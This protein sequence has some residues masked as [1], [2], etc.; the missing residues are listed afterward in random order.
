MNNKH[1]GIY[2]GNSGDSENGSRSNKDGGGD[3]GDAYGDGGG[4]DCRGDVGENE[5]YNNDDVRDGSEEKIN[6]Y[7]NKI[8]AKI[9]HT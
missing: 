8:S 1:K 5:E 9:N 3:D 2:N 6:Q 7:V 4:S